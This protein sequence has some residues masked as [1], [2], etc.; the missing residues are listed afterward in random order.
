M[1]LSP[2]SKHLM[3]LAEMIVEAEIFP[4]VLTC[5][6]DKD[7]FLCKTVASLTWAIAKQTPELIV[8][9][10][11]GNVRLPGVMLLD[12]VAVCTLGEFGSHRIQ[13]NVV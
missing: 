7:E 3:D 6:E 9:G 5:L 4:A 13:G 8:A 12:C 11:E 10:S 1:T 2:I